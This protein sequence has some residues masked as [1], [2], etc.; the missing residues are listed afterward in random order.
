MKGAEAQIVAHAYVHHA[1]QLKITEAKSKERYDELSSKFKPQDE[2]RARHIL[3]KTEDEAN[4][5]I[6]QLKGGAAFAKLAEEK[7]TDTGSAK[8][9]GDLGYFPHDAMV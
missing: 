6:K 7:S 9:G 2:V 3:V 8:Q 1:I 4:D 5:I